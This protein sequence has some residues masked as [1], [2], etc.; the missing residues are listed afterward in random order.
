MRCPECGKYVG[1]EPWCREADEPLTRRS[2]LDDLLDKNRDRDEVDF[3]R[4]I[5]PILPEPPPLY[6]PDPVFNRDN[7]LDTLRHKPEV[8]FGPDPLLSKPELLDV[9]LGVVRQF[10]YS[11]AGV[12]FSVRGTMTDKFG[13]TIGRLEGDRIFNKEGL[14]IGRLGDNNKI[15]SSDPLLHNTFLD[16]LKKL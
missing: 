5:E 13:A 11:D 10:D 6:E 1:H 15:L 3:L 14:E 9:P 7:E 16:E 12:R 4:P 8:S 2:V